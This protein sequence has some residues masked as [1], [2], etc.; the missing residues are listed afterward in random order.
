MADVTSSAENNGTAMN[1]VAD[2]FVMLGQR[3]SI[4]GG[5]LDETRPRQSY[6]RILAIS[7][8]AKPAWPKRHTE[9]LREPGQNARISYSVRTNAI[10]SR[11]HK[12]ESPNPISAQKS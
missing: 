7:G 6:E 3:G 2:L 4:F 8:R 9:I 12:H 5:Y 10:V 1:K 11:A